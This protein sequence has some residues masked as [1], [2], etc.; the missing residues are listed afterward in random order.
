MLDKFSF[1]LKWHIKTTIGAESIFAV[2]KPVIVFVPLV[3]E[4]QTTIPGF[5]VVLA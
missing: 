2:C 3:S 4:S 1:S 5:P